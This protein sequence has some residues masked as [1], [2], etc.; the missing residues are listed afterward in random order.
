MQ[1]ITL[2]HIPK[3]DIKARL[4]T[5]YLQQFLVA[6]VVHGKEMKASSPNKKTFLPR[7]LFM[8]KFCSD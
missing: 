7:F 2:L 5:D 6:S 1:P 8:I 4:N 3:D